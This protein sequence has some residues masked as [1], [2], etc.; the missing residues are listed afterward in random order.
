MVIGADLTYS[1]TAWPALVQAIQELRAPALLSV[2][3]RR[4]NELRDFQAF[5]S[6]ARLRFKVIDSPLKR[7]F[8]AD[9]VKILRI[10]APGDER[11]EFRTE[12]VYA[13]EPVLVIECRA[14]S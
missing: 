10:D 12:D 13:P 7:G 11:C 9:E 2:S 1:R 14:A 6:A 4:P 8:A 5:L 3:E